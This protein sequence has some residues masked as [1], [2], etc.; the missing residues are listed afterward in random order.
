MTEQTAL[1]ILWTHGDVV[2]V[3]RQRWIVLNAFA[4]MVIRGEIGSIEFLRTEEIER[5][6]RD[7][8]GDIDA[9]LEAVKR[10][11]AAPAPDYEHGAR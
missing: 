8:G 1:D 9:H 2:L 4:E 6:I 3:S 10:A 7:Q 11:L 5:A